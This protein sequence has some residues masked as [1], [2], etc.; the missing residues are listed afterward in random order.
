MVEDPMMHVTARA[1]YAL[2]ATVESPSAAITVVC[3]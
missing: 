2:R 3:M 1:D